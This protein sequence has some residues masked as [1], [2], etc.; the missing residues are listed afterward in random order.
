M[1]ATPS[2]PAT[3]SADSILSM[4]TYT[5]SAITAKAS[6]LPFQPRVNVTGATRLA[7]PPQLQRWNGTAWEP[8]YTPRS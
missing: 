7:I 6:A 1:P 2:S 3:N 8:Y 5:G 4:T